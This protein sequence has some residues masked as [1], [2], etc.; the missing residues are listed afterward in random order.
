MEVT[1]ITGL[2]NPGKSYALT[3]HNIGFMF[4]DYIA[5]NDCIEPFKIS[6][7]LSSALSV[8]YSSSQKYI[9]T[10]PTNFMNNSGLSV[11]TTINFYKTKPE[12][13][14]VI[15]D[16]LDIKFNK[17]KKKKKKTASGHNGIL[18]I[19]NHIGTKDF[20][21][22][23]IG[24]DNRSEVHKKNQSGADYVLG[25]FTSEELEQLPKLFNEILSDEK[26][27]TYI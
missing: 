18:S 19:I 8:N 16:D 1:I 13:L 10:K 6:K 15:H 9:F 24:I 14:I 26:F 23:R 22:V 17:Y 11:I 5:Q 2:G 20:V 25:R 3:R 4:L 21:R 12:K 7:K 27:K